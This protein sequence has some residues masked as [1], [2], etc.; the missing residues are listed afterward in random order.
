MCVCVCVWIFMYR[1]FYK[2]I[3]ILYLETPPPPKKNTLYTCLFS[4]NTSAAVTSGAQSPCRLETIK[5][6]GPSNGL[7]ARLH[8]VRQTRLVR[9]FHKRP[10]RSCFYRA[11]FR[12]LFNYTRTRY[13]GR[14][15]THAVV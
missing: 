8:D 10:I 12:I 1:N 9:V 15:K 2:I 11:V 5:Q 7:T 13:N 4:N 14:I 6:V 3:V